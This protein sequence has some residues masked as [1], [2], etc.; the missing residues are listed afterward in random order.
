[1]FNRVLIYISNEREAKSLYRYGKMLKELYDVDLCA[2]YVK[3]I[4]KNE[5]V[6]PMIEGLVIDSAV[7]NLMVEWNDIENKQIKKIKECKSD[8]VDSCNFCSEE[9]FTLQVIQE[10]L[11]GFDLLLVGKENGLT[12]ELKTL[13]KVHQKPVILVPEWDEFKLENIL[14]SDDRGNNVNGALFKFLNIFDKHRKIDFLSINIDEEI[15]EEVKKY[16][17]KIDIE[18]DAELL[19]GNEYDILESFSKEHDLIIMGNIKHTFMLEKLTGKLGIKIL[20][21]LNKPIFIG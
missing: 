20:E 6:P 1:M 7:N 19:S 17:D 13:L 18:Y 16:L 15:N 21:D 4:R 3:D 14:V 5:I 10:K 12:S 2:V 8:I 9:G 11:Q